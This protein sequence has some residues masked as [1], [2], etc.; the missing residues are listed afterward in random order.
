MLCDIS[1]W[2]S[3]TGIIC[4]YILYM[5]LTYTYGRARR[6]PAGRTAVHPRL[7]RPALYTRTHAHTHITPH[8]HTHIHTHTHHIT[9]TRQTQTHNRRPTTPKATHRRTHERRPTAHR[10]YNHG[11]PKIDLRVM[12]HQKR[13][14]ER[15]TKVQLFCR[16]QQ[17]VVDLDMRGHPLRMIDF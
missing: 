8:T 6:A 15:R 17:N 10:T 9:H 4:I 13:R 12:L 5:R 1:G 7:A 16:A 3:I 14:F 11:R 2:G